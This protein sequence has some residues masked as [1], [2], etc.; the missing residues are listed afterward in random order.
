MGNA[1][2]VMLVIGFLGSGKTTFVNHLLRKG[3]S[4]KRIAAIVND[5]CTASVDDSLISHPIESKLVLRRG[6]V[7]CS[8]SGDLT[9][10]LSRL[11]DDDDFDMVVMDASGISQTDAIRSVLKESSDPLV[12]LEH[13]VVAVDA[14]L[15]TFARFRARS[16]RL[17]SRLRMPSLSC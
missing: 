1:V 10:G 11:L 8:L 4:G 2:P 13:V 3:L 15:Y 12:A 16:G 17:W 5:F 14:V 6:C 9:R 7:C